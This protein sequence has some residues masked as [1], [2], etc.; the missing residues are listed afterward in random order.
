MLVL[1]KFSLLSSYVYD[2]VSTAIFSTKL[3]VFYYF[4]FKNLSSISRNYF[5]N[6]TYVVLHYYYA[7]TLYQFR[8]YCEK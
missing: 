7:T 6:S 4:L 2:G 5:L 3:E 1:L 8:S